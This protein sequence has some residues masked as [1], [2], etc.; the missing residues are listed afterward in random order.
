MTAVIYALVV[1]VV[2]GLLSAD[3]DA[4]W[5]KIPGYSLAAWMFL[6][7]ILQAIRISRDGE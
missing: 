1:G 5:L 4:L 3:A 2:L 7:A 6:A